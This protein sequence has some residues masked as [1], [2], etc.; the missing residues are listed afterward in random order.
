[1]NRRV[2]IIAY[3]FPPSGGAGVQRVTKFVKYLPQHGWQPSVL[4]VANASVPLVDA[5]LAQDIPEGTVIR[6][7]RTWEPS[8]ALK[9]TMAGEVV[10]PRGMAGKTRW[11]AKGLVRRISKVFL[12]PD[13]Q[14]LWRPWAIRE[15][16]R[17]LSDMPHKAVVA[18]APPFSTF[19]VG[20]ELSRGTGLPLVLDYRDEWDLSASYL[21]NQRPDPMSRWIQQRMQNGVVRAAQ[22]LVASTQSSAEALEQVRLKAGSHARVSWIYN[23]YDP[24]DFPATFF[25]KPPANSLYRLIYVGTIWAL[26]SAAPLV[27]AVTRLAEQQP[28]LAARLELVFAGRRLGPEGQLLERLSGLPCRVVKHPYLS[29]SEAISLLQSADGLCVLLS[30]L[31]GAGRVVPAK[32]FEYMAAKRPILA[33]APTGEVWNL[34]RNYPTAHCFAP[35]SIDAIAQCLGQEIARHQRGQIASANHW[36]SSRFDRKYQAG[37]LAAILDSLKSAV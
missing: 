34:L 18:T 17:L 5:S 14:A 3:I 23:G 16:K 30:D 4:T 27:W 37:Q 24:E 26:T 28:A 11:L 25:A 33:I 32:I 2:L 8:Y 19:L 1:M 15:G 35:T 21:E 9:T 12:Q 10:P 36:D 22:S 6:R 31:P 20:A 7:A 13:P 29:H